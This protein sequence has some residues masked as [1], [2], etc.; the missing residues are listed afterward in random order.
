M[1]NVKVFKVYFDFWVVL[2]SAVFLKL[3]ACVYLVHLQQELLLIIKWYYID[4]LHSKK[5]Y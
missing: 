1:H 5:C 2:F 4:W 3:S